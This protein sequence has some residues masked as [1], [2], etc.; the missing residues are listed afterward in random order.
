MFYRQPSLWFMTSQAI[1]LIKQT[2]SLLTSRK[3]EKKSFS[4]RDFPMMRKVLSDFF[5]NECHVDK[6]F[7]Q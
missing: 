4:Q 7:D 6:A 5:D 2:K 3:E 1:C